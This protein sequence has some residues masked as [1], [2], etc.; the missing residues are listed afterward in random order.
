MTR[1]PRGG[2]AR[3]ENQEALRAR[4]NASKRSCQDQAAK[5]SET[6]QEVLASRLLAELATRRNIMVTE[7]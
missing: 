3:H 1:R 4:Y 2:L 6:E 7:C 5:L